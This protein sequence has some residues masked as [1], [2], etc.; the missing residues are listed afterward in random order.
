MRRICIAIGF[1]LLVA[2]PARAQLVVIDP[3][4]L[5][6]AVLIAERTLSEYQTLLAQYRTI[7]QMAQG[8]G[9]SMEG[10]R[11]PATPIT[12]H[13]LARWEYGRPWLA[14]LNNG[15]P[16]GAA[17]YQTTRVLER[18][19]AGLQALPAAARRDIEQ[20]YATI[21]ITDSVAEMG[22]HQVAL[23]RQQSDRLQT[24]VDAL[25]GDVLNGLT[26]YHEMTVNLDK[27][28]AAELLARRQDMSANELLSHTLEQLLARGKRLRDTEAVVMNMRLRSLL[29]TGR[30]STSVMQGAGDDLRSW[31]QP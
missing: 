24:A 10:Y 14:G 31:R 9:T 7:Q 23:I 13:D 5:I 30:G 26:R 15:D 29:D 6:Q 1:M 25:Q 11:I 3:A 4:N 18:P 27:I 16:T 20:A 12:R 28:A 8:L 17:Y 21:E 22:G 19:N 2:Q